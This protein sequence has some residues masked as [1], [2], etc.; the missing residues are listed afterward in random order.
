MSSRDGI[1][2][3]C[4]V[5][6]LLSIGWIFVRT[7]MDDW[8]SVGNGIDG[9]LPLPAEAKASPMPKASDISIYLRSPE[10]DKPEYT[11]SLTLDGKREEFVIP[12]SF[13]T[14][15]EATRLHQVALMRYP[16]TPVSRDN[17][18]GTRTSTSK[19]RD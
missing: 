10:A 1:I 17:D 13:D 11:I 9:L 12:I 4:A 3:I 5:T 14:L 8:R 2:A 16:V 18:A 15:R 19:G 6:A 7:R